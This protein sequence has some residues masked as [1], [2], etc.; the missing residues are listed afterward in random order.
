[1]SLVNV[2]FIKLGG[3]FRTAGS[4]DLDQAGVRTITGKQTSTK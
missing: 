3:G 1:V 2:I 4:D